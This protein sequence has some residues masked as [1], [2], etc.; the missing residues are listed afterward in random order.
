MNLE[1]EQA[2]ILEGTGALFVVKRTTELPPSSY[3]ST[4]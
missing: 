1:N 2:P 3:P 4:Y